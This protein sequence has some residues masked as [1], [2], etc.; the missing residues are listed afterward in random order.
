MNNTNRS[1]LA[2]LLLFLL[3]LH[4]SASAQLLFPIGSD[5]DDFRLRGNVKSVNQAHWDA[6]KNFASRTLLSFSRSGRTLEQTLMFGTDDNDIADQRMYN[7]NADGR[8]AGFYRLVRGGHNHEEVLLFSHWQAVFDKYNHLLRKTSFE[9]QT[10]TDRYD[11]V[12]WTRSHDEVF[13]PRNGINDTLYS[14]DKKSGRTTK[15]TYS[16]ENGQQAFSTYSYNS[17]G[18]SLAIVFHDPSGQLPSKVS[19]SYTYFKSQSERDAEAAAADSV[20][21]K[22]R[23]VSPV[24]QKRMEEQRKKEAKE[25]PKIETKTVTTSYHTDSRSSVREERYDDSAYLVNLKVTSVNGNNK[26]IIEHRYNNKHQLF[27]DEETRFVGDE[28]VYQIKNR[29][30]Y[31]KNG[32]PVSCTRSGLSMQRPA[33]WRCFYSDYDDEKNWRSC[34]FVFPTGE[35]ST[36]TTSPK[37]NVIKKTAFSDESEQTITRIIKYY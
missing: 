8:M 16:A 5:R 35:N 27:E 11:N 30:T 36:S 32:D 23:A 10:V 25:P 22:P 26:S 37:G 15:R 18:D 20:A 6:D 21:S 28:M 31:D 4:G 12:I 17:R 2:A 33:I 14:F 24:L 29:Y 1:F 13:S 3:L 19:F 7:Y 34:R 9:R